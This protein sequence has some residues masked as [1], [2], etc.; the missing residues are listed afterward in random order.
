M[1]RPPAGGFGIA[2]MVL[3]VALGGSAASAETLSG[4]VPASEPAR[5]NLRGLSAEEVRG[6]RDGEGMGFA[7]SA[8]LNGYPGPTHVLEAAREGKIHLDADQQRAIEGIRAAMKTEA[9][10]LGRQILAL[11]AAL[12]AG[13]RERRLSEAELA[14]R[15]EEIGSRRAALRLAHLRAHF[16]TAALLRPEQIEHYNQFRGYAPSS[17]GYGHGH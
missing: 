3:A 2:S 12:E 4:P 14:H 7:R 13:F 1:N 8:E 10:V 5:P 16:L 6:L 11:E 17:L 9:Q 15:I